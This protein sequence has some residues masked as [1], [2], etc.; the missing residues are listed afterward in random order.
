MTTRDHYWSG[1]VF[2]LFYILIASAQSVALS[3]WLHGI[4]VF[5]VVGLCFSVVTITFAIVSF[6]RQRHAY[7]DLLSRWRFLAALNLVS[8]SN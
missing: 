3:V 1:V 7:A 5:L 6:A 8:V 2:T 4:N